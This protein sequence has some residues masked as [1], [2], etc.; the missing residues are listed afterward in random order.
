M[1]NLRIGT[2]GPSGLLIEFADQISANS[3]AR[4]RGLLRC[5]D[6]KPPEGLRDITPAYQSILLE[7]EG[8]APAPGLLADLLK[9]ARPLAPEAMPSHEIPVFY[10][11][12]D[13]EA[14]AQRHNLAVPEV[15]EL[16]SAPVYDVFLVGFS[17]GFPY[18]G[19]LD[20]RLHTP[21][22]DHPRTRVPVGSVAIGGGHT[23][24]YSIPSAGGWWLIGRTDTVL[25]S[26]EAARDGGS[27]K[28]FLIR[29][30]D[31][32]KFQPVQP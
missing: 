16:H 30:G 20:S 23:G 19:P 22:L 9:S 2:F 3:L 17:P 15:I 29:Q 21:R 7:F 24:I 18:L 6:E 27:E 12:P 13:L 10:D 28:A 25:F 14:L 11:G 1:D 31:R 8:Q 5:L 4:C 32:V 26:E